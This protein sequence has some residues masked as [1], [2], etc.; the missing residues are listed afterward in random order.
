M[1]APPR[2]TTPPLIVWMSFRLAIP[3]RVALPQSPPPLHQPGNQYALKSSCR[4]S[5]LQRTANSVL[6]VCLTPG[7]HR[8]AP[9]YLYVDHPFNS[10][11]RRPFEDENDEEPS[12]VKVLDRKVCWFDWRRS[13]DSRSP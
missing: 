2:R 12:Q 4:S 6:T 1:G 5:I 13:E 8:K 9:F 7:D 11:T 10:R 3:R